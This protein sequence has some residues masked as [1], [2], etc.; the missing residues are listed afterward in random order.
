M[1][2]LDAG[3]LGGEQEAAIRYGDVQLEHK[4]K[5]KNA[6]EHTALCL[7]AHIH[8][9]GL[10][11]AAETLAGQGVAVD[12]SR[13]DRDLAE[14]PLPAGVLAGTHNSSTDIEEKDWRDSRTNP[15]Y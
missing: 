15:L 10:A 14:I 7:P 1:G 9:P 12:F 2:R 4:P 5:N 6:T 11:K 13:L 8:D 3:G